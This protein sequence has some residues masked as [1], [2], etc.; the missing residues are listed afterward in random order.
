MSLIWRGSYKGIYS[1]DT[2][3]LHNTAMQTEAFL[4]MKIVEGKWKKYWKPWKKNGGEKEAASVVS[5]K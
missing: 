4:Q 2:L 5:S 1:P 3:H